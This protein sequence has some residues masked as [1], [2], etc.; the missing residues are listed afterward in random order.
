[1]FLLSDSFGRKYDYLR[2]SV[3]DRCNFR[4]LYCM[5]EDG[6]ED[7]SHSDLMSYEEIISFVEHLI[8]AGLKKV[9]ITGGEPLVRKGIEKLIIKL[10]KLSGL[11]D[12]ALTTNGSLLK[13][14][15]R[16][17]PPGTLKRVNIS[18]DTLREERF[19]EITRRDSLCETWEGIKE[20]QSQGLHPLKINCVLMKGFNDDEII[21]FI[22]L[23]FEENIEVRFIEF[24]P[25]DG[26]ETDY[27][28]RFMP[29]DRVLVE[30]EKAGIILTQ[31]TGQRAGETAELY[32]LQGKRGRVGLIRPVSKHFC[33]YC[34]RLR[35]T[36][37]GYLKTCLFWPEEVYIR[38][39]LNEPEKLAELIKMALEKKRFC[40]GMQPGKNVPNL[41]NRKMYRTGG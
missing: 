7:I 39:Y 11:E 23:A 6:V 20:A 9:R 15:L 37:D 33:E 29:L 27:E 26:C 34:N 12:I 35:L 2:I 40:H 13:D 5:G 36:A 3:T 8:P 24:M 32:D 19:K 21:D 1:M 30:A 22:N 18:L 16:K 31:V 28:N 4:C 14:F 25:L 38:P 10:S 41:K 17:V